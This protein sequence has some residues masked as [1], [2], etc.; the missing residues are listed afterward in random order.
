MPRC[1][2][3][4][5]EIEDSNEDSI[6]FKN[7]PILRDFWIQTWHYPLLWKNKCPWHSNNVCQVL[8]YG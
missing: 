8:E 2:G 4:S 1:G 5:M 6:C 7:H 3:V